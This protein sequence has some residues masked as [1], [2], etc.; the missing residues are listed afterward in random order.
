MSRLN[1]AVLV[2]KWDHEHGMHLS[3]EERS[4]RR[5][6]LGR[7]APLIPYAPP[8]TRPQ[9]SATESRPATTLTQGDPMPSV[10]D[11]LVHLGDVSRLRESM[12]E[13]LEA[14]HAARWSR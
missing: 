8:Q 3:R 6:E 1:E 14:L 9:T 12:Q 11:H 13:R 10:V 4:A 5:R 7:G 2:E